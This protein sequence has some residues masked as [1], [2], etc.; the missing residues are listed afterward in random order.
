MKSI[1]NKCLDAMCWTAAA[2]IVRMLREHQL[3]R[4]TQEQRDVHRIGRLL[5]SI[6]SAHGDMLS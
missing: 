5:N 3:N 1:I 2:P 4:R 6:M